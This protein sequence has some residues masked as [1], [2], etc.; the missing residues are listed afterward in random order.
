M[1]KIGVDKSYDSMGK[2]ELIEMIIKQKIDIDSYK[3]RS[4]DSDMNMIKITGNCE[5]G[6]TI[7]FG[8]TINNYDQIIPANLGKDNDLNKYT[9][10]Y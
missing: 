6:V 10:Y 8:D 5:P 2:F 1:K 4:D 3:L 9:K 7:N